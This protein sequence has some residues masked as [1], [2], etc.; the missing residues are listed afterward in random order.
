MYKLLGDDFLDK[1]PPMFSGGLL[2]NILGFQIIRTL[3]LSIWRLK[4]KKVR[5]DIQ[6]WDF[7]YSQFF[8]GRSICGNPG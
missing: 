7:G 3:Y 1:T 2:S 5:K 8:P 4:P 6:E